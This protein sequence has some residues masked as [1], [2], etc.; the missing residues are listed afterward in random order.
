MSRITTRRTFITGIGGALAAST[1][2]KG[3]EIAASPAKKRNVLLILMDDFNHRLLGLFNPEILTPNLDA[4]AG[5]G[6]VFTHAFCQSGY[7]GAVCVPSRASLMTGKNVWNVPDETIH[8]HLQL[9]EHFQQHGYHTVAIGKWHLNRQSLAKGF[10]DHRDTHL[11]GMLK[12]RNEADVDRP[13]TH[14]AWDPADTSAGGHWLNI[15]GKIIHSAELWANCAIDR[16]GKFKD[17]D[18]PWLMQLAFNSPH[19]P[20]QA[21]REFI[22]FYAKRDVET[23]KNFLPEHPFDN[24][25]LKIRDEK[26]CSFPRTEDA[27]RMHRREYYAIAAHADQQIGRVLDALKSN[28]QLD[29][30]LVIFTSDHGLACGEH[31][32]MGKQNLYDHS[33]RVPLLFAGPNVPEKQQRNQLVHHNSLFATICEYAGLPVPEALEA[34]SL[35]PIVRDEKSAGRKYVYAGYLKYQRSIRSERYKLIHYPRINKTQL[36]DLQADPWE[37]HDL[38]DDPQHADIKAT[39]WRD[40]P[41]LQ[42]EFGDSLK[43]G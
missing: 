39:L 8:T 21:P 29:N 37:T 23:P 22:D 18:R 4:L 26:L 34:R 35:L 15:D 11:S 24:G 1:L 13:S 43:I 40:L 2:L 41:T 38:A 33:V 32:L 28:G 20:R 19:D 42:K 16:L 31:G 9:G 10:V 36:F 6:T 3:Q 5:R 30:T 25:D 27:V 14:R 7:S 17:S 12:T